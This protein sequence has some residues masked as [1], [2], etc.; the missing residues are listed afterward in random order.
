VEGAPGESHGGEGVRII[1]C[2]QRSPEWVHARLGRL[3]G[4]KASAMLAGGKGVMRQNLL[5]QLVLERINNR[6]QERDFMSQAMR[7]G[8]E[9]EAD[10][11]LHYEVVSGRLVRPVGYVQ[12]DTLMAGCSPDGV[13]GDFDGIVEAKSPQDPQHLEYLQTG[14]VPKVYRDQVT[15]GLWITG[16]KWCDWFSYNPN[17]EAPLQMKLVRIWRDD[18][19]IDEYAQEAAFFLGDVDLQVAALRTMA[20]TVG[21]L[22]ESVA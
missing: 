6:S 11:L 13:I 14:K 10:A 17:F 22:K 2:A 12:H 5:V 15:H 1:D 18:K 19:A 8:V 21:V 7:E 4:S 3:C 16:A 9:R 20:D